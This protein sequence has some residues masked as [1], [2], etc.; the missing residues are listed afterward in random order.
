MKPEAKQ[1]ASKSKP[2]SMINAMVPNVTVPTATTVMARKVEKIEK[3]STH[4]LLGSLQKRK[5]AES[6]SSSEQNTT[7]TESTDKKMKMNET[8]RDLEKLSYEDLFLLY[9]AQS[10]NEKCPYEENEKGRADLAKYI[11]KLSNKMEM[12]SSD[13]EAEDHRLNQQLKLKAMKENKNLEQFS[14]QENKKRKTSNT[15]QNTDLISEVN[16]NNNK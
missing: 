15:E 6:S 11:W 13:D 5:N 16:N 4:E 7:E 14:E 2:N 9:K 12:D 10:G 3:A 1:V 8:L